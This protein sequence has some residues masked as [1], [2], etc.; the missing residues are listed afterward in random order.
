MKHISQRPRSWRMYLPTLSGPPFYA[1][2]LLST[3]VFPTVC[4]W[5]MAAS[6][7]RVRYSHLWPQR[8]MSN[9]R[10]QES[11]PTLVSALV[12]DITSQFSTTSG[13]SKYLTQNRT[14]ICYSSLRLKGWTTTLD[15]KVSYLPYLCLES[16]HRLSLL[17]KADRVG[18]SRC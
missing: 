8:P 18:T 1:A 6:S 4:S 13:N 5:T 7:A 16:T 14:I 2:E 11:R 10:L 3:W 12:N 15:Q 17:L 9:S